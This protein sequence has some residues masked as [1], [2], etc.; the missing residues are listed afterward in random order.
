MLRERETHNLYKQ[1]YAPLPC[2]YSVTTILICN[3]QI[4]L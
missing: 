2:E 1:L 4:L 3:W